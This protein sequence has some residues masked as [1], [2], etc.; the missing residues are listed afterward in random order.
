MTRTARVVLLTLLTST[1]RSALAQTRPAPDLA[2][3]TI[4][5]LMKI[6][7]TT[8]S[9][10][11]E[12]IGS[13]PA[14]VQVVT[15]AQI[16][17]RGYRSVADMLKDLSDFKVDL[18]SD[19]DY[20]TE[21][22]V[23]GTRGASRVVLLLDGIRISSP[24]N[25]PLP[26]LANYPVHSAQQIEI[27]YGP[28]SALYGADAFSAVVNIISKRVEDA[29]GLSASASVG[30]FGLYNQTA[31]YGAQLGPNVSLML[32]GQTL[33][34]RQP[35]LSK[36]YPAVFRGLAGQHSG[37]F[38][39]IFGPMT[40]SQPIAPDYEAPLSAHS[41]EA[42]L[43]AGGLD[44]MLFN[45]HSRV[46]TTPA[47]T[48][49]N[50]AYSADAFIRNNLLVAAASYTR[51]IGPVTST[52][53]LTFS[54]HDLDPQSG[55]RNVFT[56]ME[57]SY[58]YSYGRMAKGEE[59]FSWKPTPSMTMTTGGTFERF[60][61]IPQGADLN[62]PLVSQN[63]PGTILGSNIVDDLI[64]LRYTN[65]AAFGQLQYALTP[66]VTATF[67]ARA[68]YNTRYGATFNPRLGVVAQP[69][70][71]TTLKLLYGSA[72]LAPSPYQANVHF[73]SFYST[74]GGQ[75]YASSYWHLAN[76]DLK[77]QQK[78]TIEVDF[79]Q[80]LGPVFRLS[81]SSF[82]SRFTNLVRDSDVDQSYAGL[83][84][85]WPVDYIDYPINDGRA[86]TY[87][88]TVGVDFLQA[89]GADRRLEAHA[90]LSLADGRTWHND[91]SNG[92][93]IGAMVPVQFRLGADV[94]WRRW[95]VAPRL[96]IVGPQRLIATTTAADARM[97]LDGYATVDVNVRRRTLFRNIDVFVTIENAFDRRY[98]NIN[99]RAY[100]NPEEFIGMPQNPR[101]LTLG[102]DVRIR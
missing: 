70:S 7:V 74:D 84:H 33:Y 85:G 95:S 23:Q 76:P 16:E 2:S 87:G 44:V 91:N 50:G 42:V 8:A 61:A 96:S 72:Y 30:Q 99:T 37:T 22:T 59:Q 40:P 46:S 54:R 14:R 43:R 64:K 45:N 27:V 26:I 90:A 66:A 94:D 55:Y 69:T 98:L 28:A 39:T 51:P 35:D 24:T 82:Y 97:M 86:T 52:S 89:L 36:Y 31:S 32:A 18:A 10:G 79:Q 20:P 75:T 63:E 102:F 15:A 13:A 100:T 58:K 34:D 48:P 5:E 12:G 81:A 47:V 38:D 80:A 19:Q 6:V 21:L 83:Y 9:R 93:P 25:D 3:A 17:R 41:F 56:N 11:P 29:P 49:D 4:E 101:R 60:Y 68:D 77:P 1:P 65:T 78:K 57:K 71:R 67:G 88:G 73:G 92:L 53:T 62:A